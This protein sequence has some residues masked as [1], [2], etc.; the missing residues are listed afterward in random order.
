MNPAFWPKKCA[1][2]QDADL[3]GWA[4]KRKITIYNQLVSETLGS[5]PGSPWTHNVNPPISNTHR[6]T[7]TMYHYVHNW[8]HLMYA[9][10]CKYSKMDQTSA[11]VYESRGFLGQRPI[12]SSKKL[13]KI[14]FFSMMTSIAKLPTQI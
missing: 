4:P 3:N 14:D 11:L 2:N 8:K 7:N 13:F 5:Q 1:L 9:C 12:S 6:K 10:G